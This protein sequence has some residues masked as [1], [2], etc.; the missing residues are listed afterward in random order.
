MQKMSRK[1]KASPSHE[2]LLTK[3][4]YYNGRSKENESTAIMPVQSQK[5]KVIMKHYYED[6][7]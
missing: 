7:I 2:D 1:Q 5:H 4:Q 3:K 6:N